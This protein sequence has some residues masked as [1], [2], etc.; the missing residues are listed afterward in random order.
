MCDYMDSEGA[1][2]GSIS[3]T[4]SESI[5]L[6]AE[7]KR[8]RSSFSFRL[9]VLLTD[10]IRK[11]WLIPI[12]PFLLIRRLMRGE[13]MQER[14]DD[15]PRSSR[16]DSIILFLDGSEKSEEMESLLAIIPLIRVMDETLEIVVLTTEKGI[17]VFSKSD[18]ITYSIPSKSEFN[19][20]VA[21]VWNSVLENMIKTIVSIHLSKAF[22]FIGRF[23]FRGMMNV[24]QN[25]PM[26]VKSWLRRD[27][28]GFDRID[29]ER[30]NI[31]D[32]LINPRDFSSEEYEFSRNLEAGLVLC[33]PIHPVNQSFSEGKSKE[34]IGVSGDD[35]LVYLDI[36]NS[37]GLD[38]KGCLKSCLDVVAANES[39]HILANNIRLP[40]NEVDDSRIHMV[41]DVLQYMDSV[42][43]AITDGSYNNL[44]KL[45]RYLIPT[46]CI[47]SQKKKKEQVKRVSD[48]VS[49]GSI[50]LL[51]EPHDRQ[52]R[53]AIERM[54]DMVVRNK[55]KD[56]FVP[57][58]QLNGAHQITRWIVDN[59]V[60]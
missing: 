55:M 24:L 5:R 36:D 60:N 9:G 10:S 6:K 18:V 40:Q 4:D 38:G 8:I 30:V 15:R 13:A 54:M 47:P 48:L 33:D 52:I 17:G 42:D 32:I 25:E 26:M 28:N 22:L 43:F 27:M 49:D 3:R 51:S 34:S 37:K 7:L 12:L 45:I 19:G 31:F 46:I 57:M 53:V 23:P 1:E 41:E 39:L 35:I 44:K 16:R 58:D 14:N 20:E 56:A 50:I 29:I 11:P 59:M 2:Y 21:A